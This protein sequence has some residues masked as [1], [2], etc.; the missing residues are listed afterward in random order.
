MPFSEGT[1]EFT[2]KIIP[3]KIQNLPQN[4]NKNKSVLTLLPLERM[5]QHLNR[6][7]LFIQPMFIEK[8]IF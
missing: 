7:R 1:L 8:L 2:L 5:L 4:A 3:G 6:I